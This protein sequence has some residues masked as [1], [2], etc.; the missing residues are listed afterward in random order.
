MIRRTKRPRTA[1]RSRDQTARNI[2]LLFIVT[3]AI[4]QGT[5]NL[6]NM[7]NQK[8][9]NLLSRKGRHFQLLNTN[10]QKLKFYV[11]EK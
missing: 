5:K 1:S 6:V 2:L 3:Y 9:K 10:M 8:K 4:V 11:I 7:Q